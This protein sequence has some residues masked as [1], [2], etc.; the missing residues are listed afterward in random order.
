MALNRSIFA[1]S[2]R[3][4]EDEGKRKGESDRRSLKTDIKPVKPL[5]ETRVCKNPPL[6]G[7]FILH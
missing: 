5:R 1:I 2:K 4:T 3:S 6:T 7:T